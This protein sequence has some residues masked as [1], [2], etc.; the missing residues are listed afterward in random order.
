MG[1]LL[2]PGYFFLLDYIPHDIQLNL[3]S[4]LQEGDLL[5]NLPLELIL[6][7][8]NK[9][10]SPDVLEKILF[11]L[12]LFL[13]GYLFYLFAPKK[14]GWLSRLIAGTFY[15]I[16]PFT[17][18]RF[19]AGHFN[20]LLAYALLPVCFFYFQKIFTKESL[21]ITAFW[22]K[23]KN[24]ILAA[25]FWTLATIVSAHFFVIIGIMFFV[26]ILEPLMCSLV[27]R[28][29]NTTRI[30]D[31]FSPILK[32]LLFFFLFNSF[33][34]IPSFFYSNNI[35]TNSDLSHFQA[36][37]S[38]PDKA[39]G[40]LTNILGMY[41]FWRERTMGSE[42]ILTKNLLPFWPVFLTPFFVLMIS[43][44]IK[45][46][47][48]K[49]RK[50][51]FVLL[52][53]ITMALFFN[54]SPANKLIGEIN[55]WTFLNIPGFKGLR[56][57]E[58]ITA[59]LIFSY[60]FLIT[61]GIYALKKLIATLLNRTIAKII[62]YSF[63]LAC[64]FIFNFKMFWGL[65]G[66]IKTIPYPQSYKQA[67]KILRKEK[68][69]KILLL[70]WQMYMRY[71][72]GNGRTIADPLRYLP[73]DRII[74]TY[75]IGLEGVKIEKETWEEVEIKKILRFTD[76]NLWRETLKK[77]NVKYIFINK[78]PLE[79]NQGFN[80][81]FFQDSPLFKKIDEDRFGRLYKIL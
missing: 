40:L 64:I 53:L 79:K 76:T 51:L 65:G 52:T 21:K 47:K 19:M 80:D 50:S 78:A 24:L 3:L 8:L 72:P 6:F 4:R 77:M 22:L 46:W 5:N 68:N 31:R 71:S 54:L 58:K 25:F 45:L 73:S 55:Q 30:Y 66:Q 74:A 42:I 32:T 29:S 37:Q 18:E 75:D 1:P 59:L 33:W 27:K 57:I 13:P 62:L 14:L 2:A 11:S 10:F 49:Q 38:A 43:G 16:N 12:A 26:V 28:G 9:I 81:W 60:A 67:E 15:M 63:I 48:E 39:Y 41:G 7:V 44:A 56:E 17:Y 36:F 20:I 23:N 61:W 70:P 34:L 69:G 35:I